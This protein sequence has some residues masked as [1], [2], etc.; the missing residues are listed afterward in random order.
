MLIKESLTLKGGDGLVAARHLGLWSAYITTAR[1][2][3]F[4]RYVWISTD[5]LHAQSNVAFLYAK[6]ITLNHLPFS[7]VRRTSTK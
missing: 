4:N 1:T 7:L 2:Y 6:H 5:D 3:L